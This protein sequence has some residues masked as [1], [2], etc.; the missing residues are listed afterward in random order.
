MFASSFTS[1]STTRN[2]KCGFT[3]VELL[4]VIGIIAILIAL[5]LPAVNSA[6]EA[7]RRVQCSNNQKNIGLAVR[8]Y[9]TAFNQYPVGASAYL[10]YSNRGDTSSS[11]G[12]MWSAF[13]LPYMEETSIWDILKTDESQI[14]IPHSS[15][16]VW[17]PIIG[18]ERVISSYR[19]PSAG[20]PEH[21]YDTSYRGGITQGG[22]IS[23]IYSDRVPGSYLASASGMVRDQNKPPSAPMRL[24]DG[25]MFA[26]DSF[27]VK[28]SGI[29]SSKKR[30]T[31]VKI[32]DGVSR[33]VLV[34]EVLHDVAAQIRDGRE[35]ESALGSKKDHW[36]IGSDDIRFA[37][38]GHD[39]SEALGSFGVPL[40]MQ[41]RFKNQN[42]CAN[43]SVRSPSM[44]DCQAL[45][46]SF[47]SAHP[48][49]I[50]IC[51]CDGSVKFLEDATD[52]EIL[53]A[54]GTRASQEFE[55]NDRRQ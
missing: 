39:L 55:K 47:S 7:A 16:A 26:V 11:A 37:P 43:M 24:L 35:N 3:L 5:F 32:T 48:G 33:T 13:I 27:H 44:A 52:E 8:N 23:G 10:S 25:V 17:K 15:A 2:S 18:S 19:C 34:A 46:L 41:T 9:E 29:V 14:M 20:L 45:Q 6:R 28:R 50:N 31:D 1:L 54:Y 49:G 38:S 53:T 36:Y 42:P 40:N 22:I 21:M 30:I 12:L 4:V 51:L